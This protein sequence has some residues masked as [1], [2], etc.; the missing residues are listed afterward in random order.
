MWPT[1]TS[2]LQIALSRNETAISRDLHSLASLL[3]KTKQLKKGVVCL[4][5][6]EER[7]LLEDR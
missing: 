4:K 5:G 2:I 6:S 1:H 7:I 3:Y